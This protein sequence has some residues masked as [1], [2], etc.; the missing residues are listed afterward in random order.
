M[1]TAVLSVLLM[2]RML[3]IP[4]QV[5][6]LSVSAYWDGSGAPP[7]K[8]LTASGYY[9]RPG[10][11]ACGPSYPFGTMFYIPGRGAVVCA[12]RG[13]AITDGHIDLW[14]ESEEAAIEWG[15][16]NLAVIVV[17]P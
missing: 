4:T 10:Y 13:G 16:H 14:M 2:L 9:T 15:R 8:G 7:Y 1:T 17:A 5:V 12:D 3:G 11:C 6:S